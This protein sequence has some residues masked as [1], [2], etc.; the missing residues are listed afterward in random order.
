MHNVVLLLKSPAYQRRFFFLIF[1]VL[2]S[3]KTGTLTTAKMTIQADRIAFNASALDFL[4]AIGLNGTSKDG[5][6]EASADAS[7]RAE[8]VPTA[9]G[10]GYGFATDAEKRDLILAL[11]MLGSNPSNGFVSN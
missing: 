1:E 10:V 9:R 4:L 7:M 2:C 8:L 11:A 3:D 5:V 6:P